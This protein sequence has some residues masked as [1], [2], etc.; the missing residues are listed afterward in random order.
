MDP[1]VSAAPGTPEAQPTVPLTSVPG[2]TDSAPSPAAAAAGAVDTDK[3]IYDEYNDWL[4][5]DK[6][7]QKVESRLGQRSLFPHENGA[8]QLGLNYVRNAF[9]N[10]NY[11]YKPGNVA[12]SQ[13]LTGATQGG[14]L[15][16]TWF[17]L[18]SLTFGRLGFGILGGMYFTK[19]SYPITAFDTNNNPYPATGSSTP[20]QSVSYGARAVYEFDYFLGQ[21]LVPFGFVGTDY[22]NM[23]SIVLNNGTQALVNVPQRNITSQN[24]GG[25]VHFNLNRLEPVVAS[26]ALVNVGI[27]KFYLTY[28]ALERVGTLEG[29]T[30]NL[31]LNFEF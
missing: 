30:H 14:E 20:Q 4:Q 17:P 31:A 9:S 21:L 24:Y 18:H 12:G 16:I 5:R 27:K 28:M 25:G 8:W 26:R 10:Y 13:S 2:K 23:K 7:R 6:D 19:F 3:D 11:N 15:M 29:W 1:T 22:V